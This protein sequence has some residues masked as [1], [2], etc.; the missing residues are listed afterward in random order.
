MAR[1]SLVPSAPQRRS[2][3]KNWD[4]IEVAVVEVLLEDLACTVVG[5]VHSAGGHTAAA[6]G[7]PGGSTVAD[8]HC[9]YEVVELGTVVAIG[10]PC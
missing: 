10:Q 3:S 8:T 2:Y 7:A 5:R 6:E 9:S 4:L 1:G